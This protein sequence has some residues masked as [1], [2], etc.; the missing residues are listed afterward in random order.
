MNILVLCNECRKAIGNILKELK[1]SSAGRA[2]HVAE[3]DEEGAE[4]V[5]EHAPREIRIVAFN[6]MIQRSSK[7]L[8]VLGAL[9]CLPSTLEALFPFRGI[10]RNGRAQ[11]VD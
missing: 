10:R 9:K 3:N 5:R 11:A 8:Y 1:V 4:R 6:E 7:L 2:D